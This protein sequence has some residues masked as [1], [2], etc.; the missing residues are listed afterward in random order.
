MFEAAPASL[1]ELTDSL[2]A[3]TSRDE[4]VL[5]LREMRDAGFVSRSMEPGPRLRVS[6]GLTD[7]GR[8]LLD[9]TMFLSTW[10]SDTDQGESAVRFWS[11]LRTIPVVAAA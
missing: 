6:Y 9:V 5:L 1:D 7:D 3:G 10:L 11:S 2:P 4:L 8:K